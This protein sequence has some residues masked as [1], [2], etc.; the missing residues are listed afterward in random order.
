[1]ELVKFNSS[2]GFSEHYDILSKISGKVE[3]IY[4]KVDDEDFKELASAYDTMKKEV[5]FLS[6]LVKKQLSDYDQQILNSNAIL[7]DMHTPGN[8]GGG[9]PPPP[10]PPPSGCYPSGWE[11]FFDT[12]ICG[13]A[14]GLILGCAIFSY[15]NF[16]IC[17]WGIGAVAQE[18][19]CACISLCC[20]LGNEVCCLA[21]CAC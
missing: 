9:D 20:C 15:G 21:N 8:G 14:I 1:M 18:V 4:E 10:P 7:A 13:G 19:I 16:W 2:V 6:E 17:V 12:I 11:C 3:N 5:K